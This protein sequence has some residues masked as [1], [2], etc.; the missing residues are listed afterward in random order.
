MLQCVQV[1]VV[2]MI[3]LLSDEP[4]LEGSLSTATLTVERGRGTF[5]DVTVYWEVTDSSADGDISPTN[6]SVDFSEGQTSA[7]FTISALEDEVIVTLQLS[8]TYITAPIIG[9]GLLRSAFKT[10]L[11][12]WSKN[13]R[14]SLCRYQKIL[15]TTLWL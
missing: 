1:T 15:Y 13:E 11:F 2:L 3:Y 8:H 10:K 6:G 5:T 4:G 9:P 14:V 7:T 12:V